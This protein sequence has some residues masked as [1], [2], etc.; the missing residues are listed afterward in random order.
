MTVAALLNAFKSA[1]PVGY[2]RADSPGARARPEGNRVRFGGGRP[3]GGAPAFLGHRPPDDAGRTVGRA[4]WSRTPRRTP[5]LQGLRRHPGRCAGA[6][7]AHPYRDADDVL[8]FRTLPGSVGQPSPGLRSGA[9][10]PSG[11]PR[12]ARNGCRRSR[13]AVPA[14]GPGTG[15]GSAGLRRRGAFDGGEDELVG[16][17]DLDAAVELNA[18]TRPGPGA[19]ETVHVHRRVRAMPRQ[20]FEGPARPGRRGGAGRCGALGRDGPGGRPG[21]DRRTRPRGCRTVRASGTKAFRAMSWRLAE[22]V[23][24]AR[25]VVLPWAGHLPSRERPAEPADLRSGYC[26]IRPRPGSAPGKPRAPRGPGLPLPGARAGRAPGAAGSRAGSRVP[27]AAGS[28]RTD[29]PTRGGGP[30]PRPVCMSCE[31]GPRTGRW[32]RPAVGTNPRHAGPD[33]RWPGRGGPDG[34]RDEMDRRWLRRGGPAARTG[35]SG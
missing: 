11:S 26:E 20:A 31:P 12:G 14:A 13:C 2:R 19:G 16:A 15:P 9:A 35:R 18:G 27:R 10:S 6:V 3:G 4:G 32:G 17:G 21:R 25:A 8:A 30:A 23:P 29:R 1:M 22:L 5:R 34:G 24:A 7:T 28:L 33:R